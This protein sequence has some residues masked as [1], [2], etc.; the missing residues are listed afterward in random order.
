MSKWYRI[1]KSSIHNNGVVAAMDIPKGTKIIEYVGEKISKEEGD[2][3]SEMHIKMHEK[4]PHFGEVYVYELDDK[5]DIDGSPDYN[6]A[7]YIN[8]S[9]S[10]NCESDIKD[11][12]IWIV[13]LRDIKEGEELTYDYSYDLDEFDEYPCKCGSEKCFGYILDAE[14]WDKG[15][16]VLAEKKKV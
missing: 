1:T 15:K 11:G 10:P 9:C 13:A 8:H 16:K 2:M 3:R 5:W 6:E 14:L 12:H 7:K 4:N